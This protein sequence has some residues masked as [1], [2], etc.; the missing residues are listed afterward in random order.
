MNVV[1]LNGAALVNIL[2]PSTARTFS[3]YTSQI[4][5]P[6]ITTQLQCVQRVDAVWDEYVDGSLKE[7]THS[8]SGKGSCRQVGS[9]NTPHKNW[10]EFLRNDANKVELFTFLSMQ[11]AKLVTPFQVITTHHHDV[12]CTQPRDTTELAPCTQEEADT[13]IFMHVHDA[14]NQGCCKAMIRTVDSDVV[15]LA[16]AAVPQLTIDE[17]WI[18]FST[19]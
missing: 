5:L 14:T 3:E 19:G 9:L 18:A 13:R 12:L 16:V 4:F 11:I 2:K 15:V 17:L 6:Y 10:Q 7:N 8:T 1:I